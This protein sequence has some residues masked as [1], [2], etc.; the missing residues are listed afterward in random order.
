MWEVMSYGERPYW[1]MSDQEVNVTQTDICSFPT[2][3]S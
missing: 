3:V 1:D 2:Q